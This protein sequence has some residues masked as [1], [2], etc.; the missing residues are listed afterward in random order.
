MLDIEKQKVRIDL[1]YFGDVASNSRTTK[2]KIK[3]KC[4]RSRFTYLAIRILDKEITKSKRTRLKY[5]SSFSMCQE[6]KVQS[7]YNT[8]NLPGTPCSYSR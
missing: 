2:E 8:S 5:S 7:S 4:H 6:A 1:N 3:Y